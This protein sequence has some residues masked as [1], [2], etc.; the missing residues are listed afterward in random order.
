MA[1][2]GT[3]GLRSAW[4][5]QGKSSDGLFGWYLDRITVKTA[6]LKILERDLGAFFKKVEEA[7]KEN[8]QKNGSVKTGALKN[9]IYS[10]TRGVA[11]KYLFA[12]VGIN[13]DSALVSGGKIKRPIGYA[14]AVEFGYWKSNKHYAKPTPFMRPA[15]ASCGGANKIRAIFREAQ[16]ECIAKTG[17][18]G[19]LNE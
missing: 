9:S 12:G 17:N 13:V 2:D 11:G 6:L 16:R 5:S 4:Y 18:N 3:H 1:T 14:N 19:L 7:A 15:I 8:L 10:L